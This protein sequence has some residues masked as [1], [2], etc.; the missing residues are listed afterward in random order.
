MTTHPPL[1]TLRPLLDP[2]PEYA[3]W[4][5]EE[6]I[7]RVTVWGDT[8]PWLVTRHEDARTV[9]AD[10]RF[11]A[12]STRAGFPG[13]RPQSPPRA[14][15]QFFMMDPPD[16]TRLRR[17]LLPDFTFR[18]IGRL[19]PAITRIC[20]ELLDAM[21]AAGAEGAD[22]VEAYA[23]PLPS[24]V[25]CELLGVP[26]EDHDFFQRQ[27]RSFS[28]L[29]SGPQE[30]LA[31]RQAL[32][33]YLGELLV[34]RTR[35]PAD[36]L[37]SRLARDRVATG[38]VSAAEAV[39]IASLLLVAGHETTANMFPLAVVDLLRHPGQLAA[40]R[41]DPGLWP[42][43][44]EELLRHLTVA[45]SGLRR[46]ATEDVEVAGVRIRA[47]EGVIVAVHAANRD[48]SGF[49]D[50][51][52]LDV[53]RDTAG[54]LAFGH[55]LHQCIGQSLARAELQVGLP[56]LFDR[57]PNLRLTAP[58]EDFAFTMSTTH[59]VRSLPVSW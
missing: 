47:G 8:T 32:H 58:P 26:Y 4:R 2:A 45:H 43:A 25:I 7:R 18:R 59:G 6:P 21:T 14:P 1:P 57:L 51:D 40:L 10:P 24:L 15:G 48:P 30:M 9:L 29:A 23:M 37:V 39:G 12:D 38:E 44:V 17:V 53:R 11:S 31:A 42:G 35:E 49:A 19:R 52:T 16:H 41:A 22:L 20:G 28:S 55:G 3:K 50:P 27:A 56:A 54:H 13:F 46:I 33:T 36:D 5:A 34:R